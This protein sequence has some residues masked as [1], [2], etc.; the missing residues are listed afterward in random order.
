M[1]YKE[2]AKNSRE[3]LRQKFGD[4]GLKKD[5]EYFNDE[6]GKSWCMVCKRDHDRKIL[7]CELGVCY[8]YSDRKEENDD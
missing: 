7:P 3:E 5:C 8:F 2:Y 4:V 1:T 6:R